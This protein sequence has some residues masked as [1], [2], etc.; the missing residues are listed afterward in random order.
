M[1]VDLITVAL[2]VLSFVLLFLVLHFLYFKPV[3]KIMHDRQAK[4]KEGNK[5][6][7]RSAE[8]LEEQNRLISTRIEEETRKAKEEYIK[9]TKAAEDRA[10]ALKKEVL[11]EED[12]R[13]EQAKK[14][15]MT[16]KEEMDKEIEKRLFEFAK[17]LADRLVSGDY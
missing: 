12:T 13:L 10:Y 1:T 17:T 2:T 5:S 4:I 3:L 15:L 9:R 14:H 11:E 6:K 8:K 7:I 16:E